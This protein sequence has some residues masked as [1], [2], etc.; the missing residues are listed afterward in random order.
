MWLTLLPNTPHPKE[1]PSN[2]SIAVSAY[3]ATLVLA[4]FQ[5][6]FALHSAEPR[7]GG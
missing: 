2:S 1:V 5:G 3:V 7:G 6:S 4:P